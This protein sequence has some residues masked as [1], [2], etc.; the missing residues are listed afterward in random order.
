M[1]LEFGFEPGDLGLGAHQPDL[2]LERRGLRVATG[3]LQTLRLLLDLQLVLGG[4]HGNGLLGQNGEV[5]AAQLQVPLGAFQSTTAALQYDLLGLVSE[6]FLRVHHFELFEFLLILFNA[7]F[8]LHEG[9]PGPLDPVR[10]GT[11]GERA[12]T[13]GLQ[14]QFLLGL[15]NGDG[16]LGLGVFAGHPRLDHLLPSDVEIAPEL[17]QFARVL[18]ILLRLLLLLFRLRFRLL[19][20]FVRLRVGALEGFCRRGFLS[21]S[22]RFGAGRDGLRLA[23]EHVAAGHAAHEE[24]PSQQSDND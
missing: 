14:F 24:N 17:G 21:A 19:G 6:V 5:L 12:Q 22:R 4:F 10:N 11:F 3:F 8:G 20:G 15:G 2:L 23:P 18:G 1:S 9:E 13:L 16:M 7:V